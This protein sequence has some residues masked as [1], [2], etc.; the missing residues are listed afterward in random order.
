MTT[1]GDPLSAAR[2]LRA[3]IRATRHE[4]EAARRLVPAVVE[5]LIATGLCR[6]A[7][8]RSLGGHEAEPVAALAV[9]EELAWADASVA[10]IAW[11][12]QLVCLAGRYSAA[13]VRKEVFGD[14]GQLYASSTRPSGTAALVDGG[15]RVSGRWSLVSGCELAAWIPVMCVVADGRGP[16][17]LA[18]GAPDLRMAYI[19]N[20]SYRVLDTWHVGGLRGTG[21][22]D[23]VVEDVFVPTERTFA[24]SD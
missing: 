24:F 18:S 2:G 15:V 20:G 1:P 17:K 6:L 22:H 21:S 23:I 7:L 12:N 10:W 5:G 14:A 13:S 16:R 8:P 19:P 3:T 9:Y 4:T 11:N